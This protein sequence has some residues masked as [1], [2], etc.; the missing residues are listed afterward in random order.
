MS[1]FRDDMME[2]LPQ[3]RAFARSLAAGDPALADDL[4]QDTMVL[5]LQS[6]DKFAPGTN[7][8]AWLLTIL[9]N[10]FHSLNRR[11]RFR[12]EISDDD[13]ERR[14]WTPATQHVG[15]ETAA[16]KRAFAT[17]SAPH[18]EALVLIGVQGL[19]YDQVAQICNCEVGTVKSRVFRA[20]ELLR[21][22]LLGE[23]PIAPRPVRQ[24]GRGARS[25]PQVKI[26]RAA[27]Q[28]SG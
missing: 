15:L 6:R 14:L 27:V 24:G 17:L 8:K 18:R 19:P 1:D 7:L 20:R 4:V 12:A 9:R 10:R 16:F 3:L 25:R 2:L 13:L 22:M 23:Q 26:A 11:N 5:A 21:T 28:P